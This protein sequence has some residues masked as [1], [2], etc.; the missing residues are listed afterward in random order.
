MNGS[1]R[2]LIKALGAAALFGVPS[3]VFASNAVNVVKVISLDCPFCL[4]TESLD[5]V[6]SREVEKAGG[7]LSYAVVPT[8]ATN[9]Y[10]EFVYYSAREAYPNRETEIRRSM[11]KQAQVYSNPINNAGMA[12][13]WFEQDLEPMGMT[14]AEIFAGMNSKEI[15]AAF[16]RA[17]RV[18]IT[19]GAQRFPTYVVIHKN[20]IHSV[21]DVTTAK[22]S[23]LQ[24]RE[25][26]VSLVRKLNTN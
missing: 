23:Y 19:S 6:I 20:E 1:K 26:V 7:K 8:E 12:R 24:L 18:T 14:E 16:I 2:K 22:D 5:I 21:F 10:R 3:L 4:D 17:M 9:P 15:R 11:F 13:V 25:D